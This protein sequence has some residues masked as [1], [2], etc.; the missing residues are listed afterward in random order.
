MMQFDLYSVNPKTGNHHMKYCIFVQIPIRNI[1]NI[2]HFFQISI[3]NISN[4]VCLSRYI[5]Q[6][7]QTL[8]I[9][10]FQMS[11]RNI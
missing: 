1:S 6:T 7:Y 2:V 11:I 5:L 4:I 3:R 8:Y 9:I 10:F